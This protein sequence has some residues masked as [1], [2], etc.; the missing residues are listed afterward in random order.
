M[1]T[2]KTLKSVSRL[3]VVNF[4]ASDIEMNKT[5]LVFLSIAILVLAVLLWFYIR[6]RD[7]SVAIDNDK[8][9]AQ[10]H[11]LQ[12][13]HAWAYDEYL[14][15]GGEVIKDFRELDVLNSYLGSADWVSARSCLNC[16]GVVEDLGPRH[17]DGFG[18][19]FVLQRNGNT[20]ELV[21]GGID[22]VLKTEDD[23][24]FPIGPIKT[25]LPEAVGS[26]KSAES[27]SR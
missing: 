3:S 5:E 12:I 9:H 16:G 17:I 8:A 26:K 14:A 10:T 11:V 22:R 6:Y 27:S 15:D 18:E 21:S 2:V 24:V 1:Q 4:L 19:F 13:A 20:L 25:N 23:I 7:D